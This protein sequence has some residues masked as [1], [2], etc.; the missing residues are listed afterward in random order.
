MEKAAAVAP[1]IGEPFLSH[2]YEGLLHNNRGAFLRS[3]L[4]ARGGPRVVVVDI[5]FRIND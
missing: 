5:P 3:L 2:W 4:R 1:A